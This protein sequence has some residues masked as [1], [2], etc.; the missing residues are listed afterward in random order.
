[1]KTHPSREEWMSFLYRETSPEQTSSLDS[2]LRRCG[3]CQGR[4]ARWRGTMA[5]LDAW[6]TT[7]AP[8]HRRG[9][10]PVMRWAAAAAVVL[11]AGIAVGRMTAPGSVDIRQLELSLR[12][13]MESKLSANRTELLASFQKHTSELATNVQAV[14]TAAATREAE[15]LLAKFTQALDVQREAERDALVGALRSMEERRATDFA[16]LRKDLDTLA[17]NADDGLSRTQEQLMELASM[18]Q[19]PSN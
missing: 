1:M 14:A 8:V 12:A 7:A 5:K 2:H 13:E 17:V 4:V 18:T 6:K 11:G 10:A 19:T 16:S 15:V 9:A 3:E